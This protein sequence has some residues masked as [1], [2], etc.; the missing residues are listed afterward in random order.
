MGRPADDAVHPDGPRECRRRRVRPAIEL[1][2]SGQHDAGMD[3]RRH[4]DHGPQLRRDARLFR[5]RFPRGDEHLDGHS[6]RRAPGPGDRRQHG[7]PPGR[8]QDQPGRPVLLDQRE[9]PNDY[10]GRQAGRSQP[11]RLQPGQRH[12]G[13]RLQRRRSHRQG[14]GLVVDLLRH[15]PGQDLQRGQRRRRYLP[16]QLQ[17]QAQLPAHSLEPPR[18]PLSAGRQDRST[19]AAPRNISSP[20][21]G[22]AARPTSGTRP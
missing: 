17:R 14:Q 9:V 11:H 22:R 18:D 13:L 7:H 1:R 8:Q 16:Q 2:R 21:G 15:Q 19:A 3:R 6:G 4:A 5:L 10:L 20:G 12:Q